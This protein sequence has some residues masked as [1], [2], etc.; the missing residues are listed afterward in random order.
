MPG[1]DYSAMTVG[2]R[3]AHAVNTERRSFEF[4]VQDPIVKIKHTHTLV[5]FGKSRDLRC[6]AAQPSALPNT[7]AVFTVSGFSLSSAGSVFSFFASSTSA[8]FSL[9]DACVSVRTAAVV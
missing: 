2:T 5:S 7:Q 4:Q 3:C 8:L 9:M 1:Y 6:S